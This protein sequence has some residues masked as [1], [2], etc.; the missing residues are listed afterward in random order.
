VSTLLPVSWI[1]GTLLVGAPLAAPADAP[2]VLQQVHDRA[3]QVRTVNP[4]LAQGLI[5][6][7]PLPT[8]ARMPRFQSELFLQADAHWVLGERLLAEGDSP[9]VRAALVHAY[10]GLDGAKIQLLLHLARADR[11]AQVRG[12]AVTVLGR[13]DTPLGLAAIR[14]GLEDSS[15]QVRLVAVSAAGYRPDGAEVA[16][17]LLAALSD[18]DASVRAYAARSLG[19]LE[20]TGAWEP[21]RP[22]LQDPSGD[23]RVHALR[24][25]R[26]VN[27]ADT[28]ALPELDKLVTDPDERVVAVARS[29]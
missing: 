29:L 3:E 27:L 8:R 4:A 13:G 12:A 9:E 1:I 24:A 2:P 15:S 26:T 7:E 14:L 23:V 20:Y 18:S 21:L 5:A 22:L 25:M 17:E 10:A 11:E 19:W 6:L 28:A 16:S